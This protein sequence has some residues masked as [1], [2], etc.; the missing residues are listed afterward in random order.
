MRLVAW[1]VLF[2]LVSY[3]HAD[4]SIK[5]VQ[6]I[7]VTGDGKIVVLK[8]DGTWKATGREKVDE[9]FI[10]SDIKKGEEIG[11]GNALKLLEVKYYNSYKA[12]SVVIG[13]VKNVS[14]CVLGTMG[15]NLKLYDKEGDLLIQGEGKTPG[16]FVIPPDGT[17]PFVI[18]LPEYRKV[19]NLGDIRLSFQE[20]VISEWISDRYG[21]IYSDMK[22]VNNTTQLI[23]GR[24]RNL[25]SWRRKNKEYKIK[26]EVF[27]FGLC[28]ANGINV[29]V[30]I[31]GQDEELL[32]VGLWSKADIDAPLS[33][34]D[35]W[36]FDVE[37]IYGKMAPIGECQLEVRAYTKRGHPEP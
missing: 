1:L 24:G 12:G 27:N 34:G 5:K 31:Y 8:D 18:D 17:V 15:V 29:V 28:P 25:L 30:W 14:D 21:R 11:S 3:L 10:I 33:S 7:A 23:K 19:A 20:D 37:E 22:I 9:E 2:I 4:S 35:S 32:S 16:N 26:G 6:E 36:P 13:T